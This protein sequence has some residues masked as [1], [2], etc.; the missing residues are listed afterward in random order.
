MVPNKIEKKVLQIYCV[1]KN[2]PE[3]KMLFIIIKTL[4]EFSIHLNQKKSNL[5]VHLL[6]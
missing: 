4:T 1:T 2:D 3:L 6:K 5:Q